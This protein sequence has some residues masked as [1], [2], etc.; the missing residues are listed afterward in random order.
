M[1]EIVPLAPGRHPVIVVGVD[2]SE[3]STS[4]L[5]RAA[6]VAQALG[7]EIVV[8]FVRQLPNVG[9]TRFSGEALGVLLQ[10]LAELEERTGE[11]VAEVLSGR[12]LEWRFTVR[13]GDPAHEI[14]AVA[15]ETRATC[16]V[17]GASIHGI[18]SSVMLS[19]VAAHLLH[20]SDVS[21]VIVRPEPAPQ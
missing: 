13:Q 17:V 11:E 21:V 8:V 19:S 16:V 12:D 10:T 5:R 14:L 6:P 2:G 7:A 3:L 15:R 18:V 1:G 20:H 4:A 9:V